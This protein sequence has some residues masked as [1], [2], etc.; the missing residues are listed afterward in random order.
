MELFSK[1]HIE[2]LFEKALKT[3]KIDRRDI[4]EKV[5]FFSATDL[6]IAKMLLLNKKTMET[7]DL[8]IDI[9]IIPASKSGFVFYKAKFIFSPTDEGTLIESKLIFK[10]ES[11]F[12]AAVIL[13]SYL[14]TGLFY[15]AFQELVFSFFAAFSL[16]A[17]WAEL[18]REKRNLQELVEKILDKIVSE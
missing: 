8:L 11:L 5:I 2:V 10:P 7:I 3:G 1:E 17:V 6:G 12:F 16:F 13:L 9:D 4:G 18:T 14:V 15:G